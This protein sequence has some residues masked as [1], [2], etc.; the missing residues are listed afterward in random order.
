MFRSLRKVIGER[1]AGNFAVRSMGH[2]GRDTGIGVDYASSLR[3]ALRC[4]FRAR[5]LMFAALVVLWTFWTH[6]WAVWIFERRY[7]PNIVEGLQVLLLLIE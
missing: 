5:P 7:N 1:T 2:L 6:S 3:F 4:S